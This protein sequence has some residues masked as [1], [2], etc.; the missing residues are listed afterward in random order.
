MTQLNTSPSLLCQ[1]LF[2]MRDE[3]VIFEDGQRFVQKR[4]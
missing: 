3:A 4:A 1:H 2:H